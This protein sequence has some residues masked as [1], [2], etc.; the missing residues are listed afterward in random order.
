[1]LKRI[2]FITCDKNSFMNKITF[3]APII[4]VL[5]MIG[6]IFTGC[7]SIDDSYIEDYD[8]V[9]TDYYDQFDFSTSYTYSLPD[10]VVKKDENT[11]E[12]DPKEPIDKDYS[13]AILNAIRKNLTN[14]GWTEV[15]QNANPQVPMNVTAFDKTYLYIYYD[16]WYWYWGWYYPFPPSY[17]TG[18]KTG[19][20]AIEMGDSSVTNDDGHH[21][22][23]WLGT[24]NGILSGS[25]SS[26][27]QRIEKNVDQAFKHDPFNN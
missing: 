9:Y 13:D 17:I 21:P 7:L 26:I 24:F 2:N 12:N 5:F 1:M 27:I 14:K 16:W 23:V 20:V 3:K 10:E 22:V 18:Y 4:S 15:D 8:S 19:S 6:V 11:N 25:K